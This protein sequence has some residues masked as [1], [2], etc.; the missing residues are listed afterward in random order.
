MIARVPCLSHVQPDDSVPVE[1]I[2]IVVPARNEVS[3]I[4]ECLEGL[5]RAGSAVEVPVR[6]VVVADS[7]TD[8]TA[9]EARRAANQFRLAFDVVEVERRSVGAARRA[10]ADHLLVRLGCRGTWLA[11][12]DADSVAPDTWLAAQLRHA[13]LGASMV[14][15]PVDVVD[16]SMRPEGLGRA[17]RDAYRCA[18]R[19]H[20]HGANLSFRADAYRRA[21]GFAAIDADE[22]V[23]LVTSFL[24]A[25]ENVVWAGPPVVT[26][27]RRDARAGAGFGAYLD[28]L[29]TS[30]AAGR[31]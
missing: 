18:V 2:G 29:E 27:A 14:V 10:G 25:G 5:S 7:C 8:G 23:G 3:S 20:I 11:T 19:P 24:A 22:D 28:D 21:G 26:S 4:G 31:P 13:A 6:V 15:G 9:A 12:T 1:Q 17:A 16:W 30:M